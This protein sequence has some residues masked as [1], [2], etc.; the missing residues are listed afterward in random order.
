[1]KK[2]LSVALAPILALGVLAARSP[3]APAL[4]DKPV[5]YEYAELK[6]GRAVGI[7][8]VQP[9]GAPAGPRYTVHWVTADEDVEAGGWEDMANKLKAPAPKKDGGSV[10]QHKL[11]VLNRLST[12]GWELIE[13]TGTD[14]ATGTAN[15]TF[16]KRVP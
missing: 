2:S 4:G 14:G 16:R 15:W 10:I 12:D 6:Y 9:G 7:A 11:R 8:P 1:M 3:A 13:H 5:R